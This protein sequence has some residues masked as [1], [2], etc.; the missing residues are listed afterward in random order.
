MLNF[1]IMALRNVHL[2]SGLAADSVG[3]AMP[4]TW[5]IKRGDT[6]V[7]KLPVSPKSWRTSR[8]LEVALTDLFR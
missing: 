1:Y 6:L 3:F 7:G 8:G 5:H 2:C 4:V